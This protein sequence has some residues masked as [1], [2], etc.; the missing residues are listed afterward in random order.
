VMYF[1]R[2]RYSPVIACRIADH[3][4]SERIGVLAPTSERP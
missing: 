4:L 3:A 2:I 1:G